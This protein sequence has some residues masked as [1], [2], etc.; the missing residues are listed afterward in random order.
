MEQNYL[1]RTATADIRHTQIIAT[2]LLDMAY[3]AMRNNDQSHAV[4]EE[5]DGIFN[6]L[7]PIYSSAQE[8]EEYKK[9]HEDFERTLG[10][11][12]DCFY[13]IMDKSKNQ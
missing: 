5:I 2:I 12:L 1:I 8:T 11:L 7:I 9:H 4:R 6:A 13:N 10:N 3:E